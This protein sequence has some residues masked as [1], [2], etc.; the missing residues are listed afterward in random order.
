MNNKNLLY[1]TVLLLGI[2]LLYAQETLYMPAT[3]QKL[4]EQNKTRQYTGRPGNAYWIN[5]ADYE[6]EARIYP[7]T[8]LLKG[9]E[10]ITYYNTSP[11]T[12]TTLVLRLYQDIYRKGNPRDFPIDPAVVHEGMIITGLVVNGQDID[13]DDPHGRAKRGGT[14]L[15]INP[16][17]PVL[18]GASVTLSVQWKF[19]I[20]NKSTIRSGMYDTT[21]GFIAY[22]YPQMAVYDD[23]FGWD[24]LNYTGQQEFYNDFHNFDVRIHL[25]AGYN[26]WGTGRLQNAEAILTDEDMAKWSRAHEG[27]RVE[28]LTG[29]NATAQPWHFKAQ[30][31]PDFAFAFSNHFRWDARSV[32]M[33]PRR[34]FV[35]AVYAMDDT[36]SRD[37]C[38]IAAETIRY[39]SRTFPKIDYP[40]P[41]M[42]VF[43]SK[44][45]GGMEFPMIVNDGMVTHHGRRVG[46]TS[47]EITHTYFPFM[48]GINERRFAFMDEGMAVMLPFKLQNHLAPER[49]IIADRIKI[50][51]RIG[52]TIN[53]L[54]VM[55]PS[56]Q[57]S[58]QAY[59]NGSYNRPGLAYE[60]WRDMVGDSLFTAAMHDYVTNW[61]GK[62]PLPYDFFFT[63]NR[64]SGENWNWYWKRWFFDW[65]HADLSI[66]SIKQTPKGWQAVIVNKGGLPVP[67]HLT[68]IL[69][70]GQEVTVTQ[71]ARVWKDHSVRVSVWL[72]TDKPLKQVE[73]DTVRVPDIHPENNVINTF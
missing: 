50:Y 56:N 15:I 21:T 72:G 69:E 10:Q 7:E 51:N 54:P 36:S 53:D 67:I 19:T 3:I 31:V 22:W 59:R 8:R 39:M 26:V 35:Q 34:T 12:L 44:N 13:P 33:G 73:L 52:G 49:D 37:V 48:M 66:E 30:Q 28:T 18:P 11:D 46:L 58:G 71:S 38:D 4:Y 23:V 63:M 57:L 61:K 20:A 70:D 60:Y 41:A 6:I 45:G 68:A 17:E 25:P 16:P 43:I 55:T 2:Q 27:D 62:H 32:D 47:H 65:A 14:N 9:K 42:T 64:A 24:R 40:Y 1:F 29:G 5:H